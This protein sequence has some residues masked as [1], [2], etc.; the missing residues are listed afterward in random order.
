MEYVLFRP[1]S[2]R[3]P[4][5]ADRN[6][7][8][9]YR[10]GALLHIVRHLKP[11]KVY[12]FLTQRFQE[13]EEKDHRYSHMLKHVMPKVE[14]QFEKCPENIKNAALFDQ[15]DEP[16]RNSL[17]TIHRDNPNAQVLVNVSSGTPQMQASLYLLA[18]TLTFP[19]CA[20]QVLSPAKDSNAG[21]DPYNPELAERNLGE[22]G[23]ITRT[24]HE[25]RT[26]TFS[27]KRT[28]CVTCCNAVRAILVK[29]I[30]Q[31]VETDDYVAAENLYKSFKELFTPR[32][33]QLLRIAY[34]H[35]NLNTQEAQKLQ[36]EGVHWKDFYEPSIRNL[37]QE[38]Q[39]C[40]DYLLYLET[41][42]KRQAFND[43]S[44]ALSPAL[45]TILRMRLKGAGYDIL[46]FCSPDY[47]GVFKLRNELIQQK[48]PCFLDYL[49]HQF[50][51]PFRDGPLS[52]VQMLYYMSY[53]KERKDIDL[54]VNRFT[55]L[56]LAESTVR[57]FA[58][59]EMKGIT[60]EQIQD[61]TD[62]SADGIL[63]LLK[64]QYQKAVD[65]HTEIKWN[66]LD[67]LKEEIK[68]ELKVVMRLDTSRLLTIGGSV[69]DDADNVIG[70][71]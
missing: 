6:Y 23:H 37:P 19:I 32:L 18:A 35:L 20:I 61:A 65:I 10:D 48:E 64:E 12:L 34:A 43:Y 9:V 58:A 14:I 60:A 62:L 4:C 30:A 39:K 55:K 40:Y 47:N 56:R 59:H 16:F 3:D 27:E 8:D 63:N 42:V 68:E 5:S 52:A 25:G 71:C 22:D 49:N 15:F 67:K 36:D 17:E 11:R 21:P 46:Q 13:F 45:T 26:V 33:E 29:N 66:S 51:G 70:D 50:R 24:D 7:P 1:V 38:A 53:I 31:L 54:D 2:D 57:N 69:V 44:R 41:L 28:Q